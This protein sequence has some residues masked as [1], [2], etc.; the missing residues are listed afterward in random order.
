MIKPLRDLL[1]K[2][3]EF[4]WTPIH[5]ECENKLKTIVAS[6]TVLKNF[7]KTKDVT[8]QTD[9]NKFALECVLLHDGEPVCFK[10]KI[11][12][13]TEINYGQVDKEFLSVLLACKVFYHFFMVDV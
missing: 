3:N 2:K 9:G 11:L 10:S 5:S 4:L 12:S 1:K 13:N 6:P 8:I 7:D